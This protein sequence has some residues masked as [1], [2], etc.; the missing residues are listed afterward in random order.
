MSMDSAE[1]ASPQETPGREAYYNAALI[2][3]SLICERCQLCL[4][5]DRDL[6]PGQSFQ[7]DAYYVL[8][9]DEAYRRGWVVD[10]REHG[11]FE[12]R[13]PSCAVTDR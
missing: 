7:S 11:D 13:C 3:T 4:D 5:P 1:T 10:L 8:L 12:I 6:A 2:M 9:G